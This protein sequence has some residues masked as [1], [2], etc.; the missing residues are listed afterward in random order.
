MY[1]RLRRESG[2][3]NAY[4]IGLIQ[5]KIGFKINFKFYKSSVAEPVEAEGF[6]AGAGADL[7]FEPEQIFFGRLR[8][9]FLA[10]EKQMI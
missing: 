9:L 7:I 1:D 3:T 4:K 10:S 8:F 2:W 5:Q 6:L